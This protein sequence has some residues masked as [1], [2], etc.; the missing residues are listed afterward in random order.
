MVFASR[1]HA[2]HARDSSAGNL[3][4]S[5]SSR[6]SFCSEPAP[7][8][9][10]TLTEGIQGTQPS[11]PTTT[12]A[13]T[14][15]RCQQSCSKPTK[16]SLSTKWTSWEELYQKKACVQRNVRGL[17]ALPKKN[18]NNNSSTRYFRLFSKFNPFLAC[19]S[20]WT[21]GRARDES[22]V[23]EPRCSTPANTEETQTNSQTP[24]PPS[25]Q[26]RSPPTPKKK[27]TSREQAQLPSLQPGSWIRCTK[28]TLKNWSRRKEARTIVL[29][30][31]STLREASGCPKPRKS[32]A[33]QE[34]HC[35]L[36]ANDPEPCGKHPREG[37]DSRPSSAGDMAQETS[38]SIRGHQF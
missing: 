30:E 7:G 13:R 16:H 28:A 24:N 32:Q 29:E 38:P 36:Q 9:P 14:P 3:V 10:H 31:N 1:H 6:L 5:E 34:A 20:I 12:G 8:T 27:D 23:P 2:H 19:K 4:T 26:A 11:E 22:V 33:A 21:R 17:V 35:G 25:G 37:G 15:R 18:A